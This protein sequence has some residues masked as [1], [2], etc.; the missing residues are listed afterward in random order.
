MRERVYIGPTTYQFDRI[1]VVCI[2]LSDDKH[3]MVRDSSKK[4]TGQRGCNSN[5]VAMLPHAAV[6]FRMQPFNF[7]WSSKISHII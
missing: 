2:P 7:I 5:P 1:I 3:H 6:V 4:C